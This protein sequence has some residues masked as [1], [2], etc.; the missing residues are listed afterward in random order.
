MYD[1]F[2]AGLLKMK[3]TLP[4]YGVAQNQMV[5]QINTVEQNTKRLRN[6]LNQY[7]VGICWFLFNDF[8]WYVNYYCVMTQ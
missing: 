7:E 2:R 8:K 3:E 4:E 6:L 5:E 1:D